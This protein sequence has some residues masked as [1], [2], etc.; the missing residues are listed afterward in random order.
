MVAGVLPSPTGFPHLYNGI[1]SFGKLSPRGDIRALSGGHFDRPWIDTG[2]DAAHHLLARSSRRV[3]QRK[4]RETDKCTTIVGIA[5]DA[6]CLRTGHA[7]AHCYRTRA[8]RSRRELLH[9]THVLCINIMQRLP[10]M[11]CVV[12]QRPWKTLQGLRAEKMCTLQLEKKAKVSPCMYKM[13]ASAGL[14]L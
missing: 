5:A 9:T 10:A 8:T 12:P 4:R 14:A 1:R 11:Y 2:R 3:Q 7:V 13:D 6:L